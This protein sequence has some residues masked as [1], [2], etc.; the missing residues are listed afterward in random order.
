MDLGITW[1]LILMSIVSFLIYS[2]TWRRRLRE[3]NMPPAPPL[4][5]LLGNMLQ[6]SAKEFPQSLIKLSEKLGPVFTVYLPN[7]PAVVLAG[8]DCIKEA[9]LDNNECFGARGKSPLGYLL[10]K[11]YGVLSSNGTR[12]KQLRRFSLSC[13]RDLGMGKRS[14]EER[15]Q[16][17]AKYLAE[18]LRQHADTPIDPTYL[19][20]LA[21]SNVI[22]SVVFGERFDYKDEKFMTL[23][24]LLK[25]VTSDLSSAWGILLSLFPKTLSRVPGPPQRI[26][27]NFDK[28]KAFVAESVKIHQETLNSDCP[29]DFIDSFLIKMEKEKNNPQTE[30]HLDNL[31]GTVLDLFIAGTETTSVTLKYSFL[32][33]LKYTE[34]TRKTM[35]EIDNIIGQDRCPFYEDRMKMPYTNAVFHEIQRVADIVPFG[36]PH[37]TT[38]DTIFRGYN[39]PKDT[40]IFPLMTSVLKD[41]KYFRDPKQFDPAH[42]LDDNG[43]FKKNDAFLPFS[44]GKRSC[45]GE[46]LARMEIFIFLTTILQAF[47]LKSDTANQDIDITPEPN[48]NGTL[49]R[50]YK[51]YFVPK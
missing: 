24:S 5:P 29:R 18:E 23:I 47:N 6:I 37:G 32:M 19:L 22:C 14:I 46:G 34:F 17:E 2:F 25:K 42:F 41:P 33:L 49:P 13:L 30:F 39:I 45:L 44:I 28:L 11:D 48:K 51:M 50:A 40:L 7:N 15:I 16:E 26:F 27:R 3:K 8:Y 35:E 12:W 43:R 9:L 1:S 36:V 38:H 4:L 10:F 31:L 21:V 20:T